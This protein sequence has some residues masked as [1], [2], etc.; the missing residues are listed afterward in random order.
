VADQ[1]DAGG[2]EIVPAILHV[3][4][5]S[6]FASVEVLDDPSLAGQP[7][8]VGGSGAR[9]VVASCTYEARAFGVHSAMPSLRAR[10]LCPDAIFVDGH[11]SRYAAMSQMLR[12]VLLSVTPLVEPIGLDEAFLDVTGARRLLGP[13]ETIAHEIR[14]RVSDGLSLDCSVG[15]GRSKMVAK[16]ASR[17]AK[18]TADRTG[19][20]PGPGV[21]VVRP[22]DE[23]AF[24]HP[25]PVEALWGVGPATAK[26]L[27]DVG[28]RT[29]GELA[30][31]DEEVVVRRVGRAH[32]LHLAALARADDP[33]VVVPDRP[34]KSVGH[35]ETFRD[36]L[37]DPATLQRHAVRMAESVAGHLRDGDLAART[38]TVKVKF[39]DF[40]MATRSHTL[41]VA[42]D[43]GGA[44][45][46]VAGALL[47]AVDPDPGVRLLGISVSGLQPSARAQQLVFDLDADTDATGPRAVGAESAGSGPT[48][49]DERSRR[50]ARLQAEWADVT[51]A[52]DAI[53]SRFGRRAVCTVAMVGD[54][55][56]TVPARREAPWGP[57]A[58]RDGGDDQDRPRP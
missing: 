22:D 33:G 47:D 17:A 5:D 10:Q 35:E 23:L 30:A 56:I 14:Q 55:G 12:D 48:S 1:P 57:A 2:R 54:D 3:D 16:L 8:I 27:H 42:V 6:F 37:Y 43:T 44:I 20:R 38:V 52:V 45:A 21:V 4:M 15:V 50:A 26:R 46:A 19:R 36:D 31:L 41:P 7:V 11:Y 51:A 49:S 53:R 32:G 34:A 58:D 28:V 18:P 40:T 25:L 39:A 24:L 29:V 13:P 9:G